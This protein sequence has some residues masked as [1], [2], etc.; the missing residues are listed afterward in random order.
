M[1]VPRIASGMRCDFIV[2]RAGFFMV[3]C[4]DDICA[5]MLEVIQN[6]D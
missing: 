5:L 3:N 6:H 2:P 1:T 4:G